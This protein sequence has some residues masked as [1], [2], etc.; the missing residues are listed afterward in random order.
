MVRDMMFS[1]A[2]AWKPLI[3]VSKMSMEDYNNRI[4]SLTS[5]I[6]TAA[7]GNDDCVHMKSNLQSL[8][9]QLDIVQLSQQFSQPVRFLFQLA[10]ILDKLYHLRKCSFCLKEVV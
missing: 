8:E 9:L 6:Y 2:L 10:L 4:L 7:F 1:M 5:N 3:L